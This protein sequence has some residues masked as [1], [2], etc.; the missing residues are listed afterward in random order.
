MLGLVGLVG[1]GGAARRSTTSTTTSVF[2]LASLFFRMA[3][4]ADIHVKVAPGHDATALAPLGTVTPLF[5]LPI[6][7]LKELCAV[8]PGLPDLTLWYGVVTPEGEDAPLKES[9]MEQ[10]AGVI[11]DV[12]IPENAPPPDVTPDFTAKQNYLLP[13]SQTINGIDAQYSWTFPGGDGTGVT[14]Y[15]VEYAWNLQ[16]EDLAVM[17]NEKELVNSNDEG[18]NPWPDNFHGTAVLG[19]MVGTS[20]NG[21]GVTGISP[22]AKARVAPGKKPNFSD[23]TPP[24]QSCW[25]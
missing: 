21:F 22:G 10:Y 2:L 12:V 14:I 17:H 18:V 9:L 1:G 4:A 13:N 6:E 25:Q 24:M 11:T 20:T 8:E 7:R 3:N 15:D 5:T 23:T 19:E 16:H